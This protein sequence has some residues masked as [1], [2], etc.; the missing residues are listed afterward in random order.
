VK[1]SG[2]VGRAQRVLEV[3]RL[4]PTTAPVARLESVD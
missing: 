4:T 1:G 2:G 3:R